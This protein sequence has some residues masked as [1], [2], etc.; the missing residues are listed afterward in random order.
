[1]SDELFP[2]PAEW[3]S[4]ALADDARYQ[5]M[6]KRSIDDPAGFWAEHGKRVDWISPYSKV[7]DVSYDAHDL[8][9]KWF[10]D[11]TLNASANCLDRHLATRGDQVAIIWEGDDPKD[12]STL[13]YRE[14]H[15]AVCRFANGL[16][17]LG[18]KKG[19]V[20]TIYL[21]MI[22]EIAIAMLACALAQFTRWCSAVSRRIRSPGASRIAA[23]R[24]SSPRT[25]ACGAG[26]PF[27]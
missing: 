7:K 11:G 18:V 8:H 21:P 4:H 10:Y 16:R 6:Y 2:V 14:L 23:R 5:E 26:A 22:P 3:A 15:A 20:V 24:W 27:H 25:R 13:T 17:S 9:I 19:D 12:S 1:M